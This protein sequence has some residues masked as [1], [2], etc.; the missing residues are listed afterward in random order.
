[1]LKKYRYYYSLHCANERTETREVYPIKLVWVLSMIWS[2][3]TSFGCSHKNTTL[4]HRDWLFSV[5][6]AMYLVHF[7]L[8]YK[9]SKGGDPILRSGAD[10][11]FST[12][13]HPLRVLHKHCFA[14]MGFPPLKMALSA[15]PCS[16]NN[17]QDQMRVHSFL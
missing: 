1:M 11:G 6:T 16:Q 15:L 10:P 2:S 12:T 9:L 4:S 7:P 17:L 5:F 13:P 3:V 14:R 8:V